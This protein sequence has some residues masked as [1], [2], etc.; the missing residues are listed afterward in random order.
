MKRIIALL[1]CLL[2]VFPA[3]CTAAA[4]TEISLWTY[5]IGSWA[6]EKTV[7]EIIARFNSVHPEITVKVK[8]L[9]YATGDA[10]VDEAIAAGNPPDIIMEGPERLVANWGADGRML[11]LSD[12]WTDVLEDI[13]T[14]SLAVVSACRNTEGKYYVYPLCM[15]V[16]CM[17][18]NR[19][20]FEAADAMQYVDE[21]MHTW[22]TDDF[23]SALKALKAAGYETGVVYCGGQGGDQGTRALVTNLYS[24]AFTDEDHTRYTLDDERNI[25]ALK[26]LQNLVSEGLLTA[27][28]T[29][30]ASDEIARFCHGK[31]SIEFCW[32][33]SSAL[34]NKLS[35][36]A[37]VDAF[38]IA[39]P[40]DN[41]IPELQGG[42]WGFGIFDNG[43]S[44]RAEA[45]KTF[46]RYV[47]DDPKQSADS[48]YESGF[49]PT[50]ESLGDIYSGTDRADNAEF[51]IFQPFLGDYY[52]VTRDWPEQRSAW[53]QMLQQIFSGTD[54]ESAVDVYMKT[55]NP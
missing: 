11:D 52:Q 35:M 38:P 48:V 13:R 24:G 32:N 26:L 27:D 37:S 41:G 47:C 19:N 54:V 8:C 31:T 33:A 17:V 14:A 3:V 1:I 12:M 2:I 34:S 15:T 4:G 6:N 42:I 20:V 46:I 9:D 23:I 29:T 55:V 22:T 49:F 40:T 51:A 36:D 7:E 5:P 16:H 18:I 10:L 30:V 50:R 45:A 43:D 39:F 25:R 44:A 28:D 53:W 21:L